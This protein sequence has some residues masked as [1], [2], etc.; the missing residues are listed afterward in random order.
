MNRCISMAGAILPLALAAAL[1]A[2]E[3]KGQNMGEASGAGRMGR[4]N[5]IWNSPSKDASGVM[6]IGNG[7]IAAGD[8]GDRA[9]G[10]G[11]RDWKAGKSARK[12][13]A[14]GTIFHAQKPVKETLIR[15][16][17]SITC[18]PS[19][20]VLDRLLTVPCVTEVWRD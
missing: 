1:Y 5:V 2:A 6:P 7:D 3:S 12:S 17:V 19:Q 14:P 8:N 10:G 18:S 15:A 16:H 9:A 13:G 11:G 20:D 4:Y